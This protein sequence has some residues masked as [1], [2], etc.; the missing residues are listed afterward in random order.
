V[1]HL[2]VEDVAPAR[3]R[4]D[5]L[6]AAVTECGTDI[7]D[8]LEQAIFADI[9]VRPDRLDQLLLGDDAPSIGREHPQHVEGLRPQLDRPAIQSAQLGA[10][11]IEFIASKSKQIPTILGRR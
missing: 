5:Q 10:L 3:H 9:E 11:R 2:D 6:A 7:P 1:R 4:A 8:A